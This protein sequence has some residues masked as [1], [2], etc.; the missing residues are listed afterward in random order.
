M[1]LSGIKENVLTLFRQKDF[2]Y[3]LVITLAVV[4]AY[5]PVLFAVYHVKY[6]FFD[7]NYPF[8]YF[9][10]QCLQNG[11]FPLWMP[12]Q[13]CG[14]PIMAD[15]QGGVWYPVS[16][17]TGLL[18]GGN[19]AVQ[20]FEF[21]FHIVLAGIGFYNL[22]NFV[23]KNKKAALVVSIC[24]ALG[25]F[26]VGNAQ[27]YSYIIAGTW[28]PFVLLNFIKTCKYLHVSYALKTVLSFTLLLTGGYPAFSIITA[29]ILLLFFLWYLLVYIRQKGAWKL[30]VKLNLVMLTG[31]ILTSLAYLTAVIESNHYITR[32]GGVDLVTAMQ[33]PFSPKALLSLIVPFSTVVNSVEVFGSDMSMI[34]AYMGILTIPLLIFSFIK[35]KN[36]GYYILLVASL[37]MLFAS[38]GEGFVVRRFL[39]NYVPFMDFFRFPSIFRYFFITGI[40]LATGFSIKYLVENNFKN[41]QPAYFA[42]LVLFIMMVVVYILKEKYYLQLGSFIK[43][44]FSNRPFKPTIQQHIVFQLLVQVIFVSV[45]VLVVFLKKIRGKTKYVVFIVLVDMIFSCWLNSPSTVYYTNVKYS[46]FNEYESSFPKGFPDPSTEVVLETSDKGINKKHYWKNLNIFQKQIAWDGYNPFILANYSNLWDSLPQLFKRTLQNKAIYLS[47]DIYNFKEYQEIKKIDSL[48]SS[49]I[50]MGKDDYS[51]LKEE[52]LKSDAADTAKFTVYQPNYTKIEVKSAG[53][54]LLVFLQ[55]NYPGWNVYVNGTKQKLYTVNNTFMAVLVPAGESM[56]EF[57]FKPVKIIVFTYVSIISFLVFLCCLPLLYRKNSGLFPS[58]MSST[59]F[60][61]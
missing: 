35:F 9:I 45:F 13:Y 49:M 8:R 41:K 53:K 20:Q 28:I 11:V 33:H 31:I 58:S 46:Y 55:N 10:G 4:V 32:G 42:V 12:Y 14:Y 56:V 37:F 19:L 54:Q 3:K 21:V 36:K 18:S 52:G 60:R 22:S 24:F 61:L 50:F 26:F 25:G 34:N 51:A 29:Y 43:S 27:H 30:Y 39:Y 16:W 6:D 47:A 17:I 40:L 44:N 2:R 1:K 38:F 48:Q 7:Q 59:T 57:R 15:P 5:Y 23:L